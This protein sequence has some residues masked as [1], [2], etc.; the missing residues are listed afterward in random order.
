MSMRIEKC[1]NADELRDRLREA[2]R[3]VAG[4]IGEAAAQDY[5]RALR[6]AR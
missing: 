1:K 6:R 5:V 3:L 2:E 4:M